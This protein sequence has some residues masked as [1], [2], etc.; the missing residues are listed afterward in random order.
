VDDPQFCVV[1]EQ[2]GQESSVEVGVWGFQL[3][4]RLEDQRQVGYFPR[5]TAVYGVDVDDLDTYRCAFVWEKQP[6]D[7]CVY[8]NGFAVAEDDVGAIHTA[9][10]R[11]FARLDFAGVFAAY[12]TAGGSIGKTRR[13][14]LMYR[15]DQIPGIELQFNLPANQ[16]YDSIDDGKAVDK[17]P[18]RIQ[19]S[20]VPGAD[21]RFCVVFADYPHDREPSRTWTVSRPKYPA[22]AG[23]FPW[24]PFEAL[25]DAFKDAMQAN[26]VH[27]GQIA[28]GY[29]GRLVYTAGC[30]WAPPGYPVTTPTARFRVGSIS[31]TITALATCQ[32]WEQ[33]KLYP[34]P[35]LPENSIASLLKRDFK[36]QRFQKRHPG[37]LLA[38]LGRFDEAKILTD[39]DP[40]Q[41]A[42]D[43]GVAMPIRMKDVV[44]WIAQYMGDAF[45]EEKAPQPGGSPLPEAKYCGVGFT[46]LAQIC[47]EFYAAEGYPSYEKGV[48]GKF[49]SRVGVNRP[50]ATLTKAKYAMDRAMK[51]LEVL[52]HPS[53]P[54]WWHSQQGDNQPAPVAYD[55]TNADVYLG[56]GAWAMACADYA[57]VLAAF[58]EIPNP[59]FDNPIMQGLILIEQAEGWYRGFVKK[60][61]ATASGGNVDAMYH[62]G[63]VSGGSAIG[64]RRSDGVVI[65]YAFNCDVIG[66]GLMDVD[67]NAAVNKVKQWPT[68]DLFPSV[69]IGT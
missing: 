18:I 52:Y 22:D 20:S 7:A 26:S 65:V 9:L 30:T 48:L 15:D 41:V 44:D 31:K 35:Y 57:R 25:E 68:F 53:R 24:K 43:L 28:V 12:S 6:S 19:G 32:L 29:K 61:F 10:T 3:G 23:P 60:S 40:W 38:H 45:L 21:Q 34:F 64:F 11:G 49:F 1:V 2:G 8:F 50:W 37:Q 17:W 27:A 56:N 46:M 59:L 55:P 54:G 33:G 13:Y 4:V 16:V 66:P 42:S 51:G 62:N 47:A 69:G 63:M 39:T 58:D 36:D 67:A 5:S 14:F